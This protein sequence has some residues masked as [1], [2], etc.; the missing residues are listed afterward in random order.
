MKAAYRPYCGGRTKRNGRT[1][2]GYC[3]WKLRPPST[4]AMRDEELAVAISGVRD[5][6]SRHLWRV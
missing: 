5:E 1:S 4:R 2:S 6:V 3:A